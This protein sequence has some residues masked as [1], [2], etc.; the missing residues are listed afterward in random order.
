MVFGGVTIA[1]SA[2]IGD[3]VQIGIGAVIR[4]KVTIGAGAVIGMGA[5]VTKDVREGATVKGNPA[6]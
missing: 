2:A 1:G 5:V 6:K 4:N 3:R